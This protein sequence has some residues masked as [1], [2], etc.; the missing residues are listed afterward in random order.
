LPLRDSTLVAKKS[1]SNYRDL[2]QAQEIRIQ[3][4]G[5]PLQDMGVDPEGKT[6]RKAKLAPIV[7][8]AAAAWAASRWATKKSLQNQ[9]LRKD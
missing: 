1:L 9:G 3:H 4:G 2:V 7:L 8:V 5:D 6:K